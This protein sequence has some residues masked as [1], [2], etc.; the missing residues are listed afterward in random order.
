MQADHIKEKHVGMDKDGIRKA[1]SYVKL[2]DEEEHEPTIEN[3][4]QDNDYKSP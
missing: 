1:T 2:E 4:V 3:M